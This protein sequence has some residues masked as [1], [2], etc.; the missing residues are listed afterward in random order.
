MMMTLLEVLN[1]HPITSALAIIMLVGA[2][3]AICESFFDRGE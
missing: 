3:A 1:D 2:L